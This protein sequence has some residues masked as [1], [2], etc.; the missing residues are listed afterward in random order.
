MFTFICMSILNY[1]FVYINFFTSDYIW[2]RTV[3]CVFYFCSYK[4]IPHFHKHKIIKKM[5]LL[6]K[7]EIDD[8]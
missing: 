2:K 4:L 3:I 6:Y 8:D 5:K 1:D 7:K